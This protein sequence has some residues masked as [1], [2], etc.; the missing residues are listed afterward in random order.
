[1][2]VIVGQQGTVTMYLL[3]INPLRWTE[4]A[5]ALRFR[6]RG[7]A[8]LYAAKLKIAVAWSIEPLDPLLQSR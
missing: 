4:R 6:T 5:Q 1:M 2:F 7:D 8:R 3:S